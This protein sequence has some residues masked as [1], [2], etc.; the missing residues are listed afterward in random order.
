MDSISWYIWIMFLVNFQGQAYDR[1][2]FHVLPPVIHNMNFAT[3]LHCDPNS[4]PM[5]STILDQIWERNRTSKLLMIN[6]RS[7]IFYWQCFGDFFPN[8]RISIDSFFLALHFNI[9]YTR[10]RRFMQEIR[11]TNNCT[12]NRTNRCFTFAD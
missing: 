10:K 3:S 7:T 1:Q 12:M 11:R 4:I 6:K 9:F 5:N 2:R 8:C